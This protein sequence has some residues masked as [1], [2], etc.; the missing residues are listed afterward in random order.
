MSEQNPENH[1]DHMWQMHMQTL[2]KRKKS[3]EIA[4]TI[5]K[6]LYQY[7]VVENDLPVPNWRQIKDPQWW[8]EYL[9]SMGIDRRNK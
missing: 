7:Y 3:M 4:Q 6:A 8:L 1:T 5:D 9:D 2:M